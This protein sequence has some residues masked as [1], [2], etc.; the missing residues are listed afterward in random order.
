MAEDLINEI[1]ATDNESSIITVVG[2]GGAGGNAVNH[3]YEL[4]ITGVKFM[5]CNTDRQALAISPVDIKIQLGLGLGAGNDPVKGRDAAV[6]SLDEVRRKFE[7]LGTKMIFIAAGMGGG[8]G[9]GASPVIAKLA[10]EMDILTVAIVTLPFTAEGAIR[11]EQACKG[12]EELKPHVD[13]LLVVSNDNISKLYG[14]MSLRQAF[15]KADDVLAMAAKGIAE[16]ITVKSELKV[17]ID[18]A[19]VRKVLTASGRAHM[20]VATAEGEKRALEVVEESLRSPLLDS[21][22]AGSKHIL[23]S[24]SVSDKDKLMLDEAMQVISYIQE[25]ASTRDAS[26]GKIHTANII[27]GA[28]IKPS[29]GDK[30]ELVLVATGFGDNPD[31]T[32]VSPE[33]I[34]LAPAKQ[35]LQ[36]EKPADTM[37]G[38]NTRSLPPRGKQGKYSDMSTWFGQPAYRRRNMALETDTSSVRRESIGGERDD[39]PGSESGSLFPH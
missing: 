9:T 22:I 12:I 37:A 19:D 38:N 23:V 3:M 27:W 5:V 14:R 11:Y 33:E 20:S 39:A 32:K 25:H 26:T 17:N 34:G 2:V 18:F 16:I 28:N 29:L 35:P 1:T 10:H 15:D 21:M 7:S 8:T 24:L 13:S 36:P 4:G 6:E 31:F 30:L